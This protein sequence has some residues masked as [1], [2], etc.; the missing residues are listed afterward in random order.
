VQAAFVSEFGLGQ[1]EFEA[2]IPDAV[3]QGAEEGAVL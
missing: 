2:A 3:A 1:L